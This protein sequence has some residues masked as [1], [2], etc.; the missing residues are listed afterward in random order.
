MKGRALRASLQ[1]DLS[2]GLPL[3]AGA[4]K[5]QGMPFLF[6]TLFLLPWN[7]NISGNYSVNVAI[8]FYF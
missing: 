6:T 1:L 5:I 2:R 3:K 7:K 4:A 8:M